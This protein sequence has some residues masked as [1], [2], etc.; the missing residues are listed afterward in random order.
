LDNPHDVSVDRD[1]GV[2]VADFGNNR[3]MQWGAT[4]RYGSEG[5]EVGFCMS[6]SSVF[7]DTDNNVF[8]TCQTIHCVRVWDRYR[9][10]RDVAG[11]CGFFVSG[12][13]IEDATYA[14]TQS[15][16][17]S[18]I[19][20]FV[21]SI[22]NLIISDT[23]NARIIKRGRNV[24][25]QWV[26]SNTDILT[27]PITF[28]QLE[29]YTDL[30]CTKRPEVRSD[31]ASDGPL[32]VPYWPRCVSGIRRLCE[33][34]SAFIG[35]Q[36]WQQTPV[37][38]VRLTVKYDPVTFG[39]FKA[40]LRYWSGFQYHT[41]YDFGDLRN[42][43]PMRLRVP[44][45]DT[46]KPACV[47][48][49]GECTITN[50]TGDW[51]DDGD[52]I[53]VKKSTDYNCETGTLVSGFPDRGMSAPAT[54]SGREF[55]LG[56][57][58]LGTSISADASNRNEYTICWCDGRRG[59]CIYAAHFQL[60]IA[61]LR[62]SGPYLYLPSTSGS[63]TDLQSQDAY[64]GLA[65]NIT[66]V[67]GVDL[68]SQ[69][70]MVVVSGFCGNGARSVDGIRN[71]SFP[72]TTGSDYYFGSERLLP[73]PGLYTLCWCRPSMMPCGTFRDFK[74]SSGNLWLVGPKTG[75]NFEC[76]KGDMCNLNFEG[77]K[78]RSSDNI[79]ILVKCG[80][81]N[82]VDGFNSNSASGAT[83]DI[84]DSGDKSSFTF[85]QRIQPVVGL[86]FVC[87][88]AGHAPC[89]RD[90]TLSLMWECSPFWGQKNLHSLVS[91]TLCVTSLE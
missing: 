24:L 71:V 37:R 50:L 77:V 5:L 84:L 1:Y 75:Q 70:L 78:L 14:E 81:Q 68:L 87:W 83:Q 86:Y 3:I 32:T 51:Q 6:P 11:E 23:S 22:G 61:N 17:F 88:C 41:I 21:D 34:D 58:A 26:I 40:S 12:P 8:A 57:A 73:A 29:F 69:D 46:K 33:K 72:S 65:L 48:G 27:E 25:S 45:F 4:S 7:V 36:F 54:E 15:Q 16:F 85:A 10:E 60:P 47:R 89:P 43:A 19:G 9:R 35:K 13:F 74:A 49:A 67:Q 31:L 38:C 55:K 44:R 52:R 28:T 66:N 42:D 53:M 2:Y 39:T 30:D 64:R 56:D 79:M 20:V 18:P 63:K 82:P 76:T 91:W 80:E 90:L 59:D 62:V